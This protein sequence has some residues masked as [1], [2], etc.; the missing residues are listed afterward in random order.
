M[1]E[2]VGGIVGLYYFSWFI[3]HYQ[4]KVTI[5]SENGSGWALQ[6]ILHLE[7]NA[8]KYKFY[9]RHFIIIYPFT[10][11]NSDKKKAVIIIK[12]NDKFCFG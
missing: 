9:E 8:N 11:G 10:K 2:L 4:R 6:K 1:L 5:F 3:K 12:I 7:V